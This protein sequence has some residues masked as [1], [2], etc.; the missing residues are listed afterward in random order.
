MSLSSLSITLYPACIYLSPEG[1]ICHYPQSHPVCVCVSTHSSPA[2]Q[3]VYLCPVHVCMHVCVCT[4]CALYPVP[5]TSISPSLSSLRLALQSPA[6]TRW[7]PSGHGSA[8][9]CLSVIQKKKG[10]LSLCPLPHF[11]PVRPQTRARGV[12]PAHYLTCRALACHPRM[13]TG[14]PDERRSM[15]CNPA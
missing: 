2:T 5:S 4:V 13:R 14:R 1:C 7:V 15:S 11:L 8:W 3:Q 9:L 10:E 12:L 6:S